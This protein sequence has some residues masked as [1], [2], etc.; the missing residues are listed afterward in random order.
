MDEQSSQ[1]SGSTTVYNYNYAPESPLL[2]QHCG[3]QGSG[4]TTWRPYEYYSSSGARYIIEAL[5]RDDLKLA[6]HLVKINTSIQDWKDKID[7]LYFIR[8]EHD[9]IM[10]HTIVRWMINKR[11]YLPC[12]HQTN[13]LN[14]I[15]QY[16]TYQFITNKFAVP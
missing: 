2:L 4:S 11:H 15:G 7:L 5:D 13:Y 3:C 9:P 8:A 12:I 6:F 14:R 10:V 1:G 16:K